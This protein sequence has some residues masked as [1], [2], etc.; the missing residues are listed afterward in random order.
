MAIQVRP[1]D[2]YLKD[3][4]FPAKKRV[5]DALRIINQPM[6]K[7]LLEKDRGY[8]SFRSM[9]FSDADIQRYVKLCARQFQDVNTA[10][11]AGGRYPLFSDPKDIAASARTY[12]DL[13]TLKTDEVLIQEFGCIIE[14]YVPRV[15]GTAG[16]NA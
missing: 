16:G 4:D 7:F 6:V 5:L 8:P 10:M 11:I 2:Y 3:M 14:E 12:F 1:L 15:Y 9:G 13:F